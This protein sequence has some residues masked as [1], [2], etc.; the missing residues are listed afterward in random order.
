M[1]LPGKEP[2]RE[3]QRSDG[4][5]HLQAFGIVHVDFAT[6]KPNLEA[7]ATF[8]SNVIHTKGAAIEG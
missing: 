6:Q 4:P 5:R 3:G 8:D 1:A 2:E 7:S